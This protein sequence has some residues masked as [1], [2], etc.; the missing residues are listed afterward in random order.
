MIASGHTVTGKVISEEYVHDE[1]LQEH[2]VH[3]VS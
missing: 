1:E 3:W 2:I